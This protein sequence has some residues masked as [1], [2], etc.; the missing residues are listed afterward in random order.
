MIYGYCRV[1]TRGQARDGNGLEVQKAAVIQAGA[2]KVF[3][4]TFTGTKTHRPELDKLLSEI[5]EGDKLIVAKLDRVARSA[6][7]G[8]DLIQLLIDKGV[9]VHILN[10]GIL[11]NTPT[12]KLIRMIFL[13]FAEFERDMIV[14]RTQEGKAIARQ[15]PEFVDGRPKKYKRQQVSHALELLE[16]HSYK[17]VEQMT[18]ISKSTLI[19]AKRKAV[20]ENE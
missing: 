9:T 7:Q 10:M 11:D 13:A 14:E 6:A 4:D 20:I 1:S 16:D 12:G 15:N 3:S 5:N 17:E 18:G 2:E 19:R 8:A